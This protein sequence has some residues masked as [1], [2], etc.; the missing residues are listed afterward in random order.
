MRLFETFAIFTATDEFARFSLFSFFQLNLPEQRR[1]GLLMEPQPI[2][3]VNMHE[4]AKNSE[5]ASSHSKSQLS[6]GTEKRDASFR[7]RINVNGSISITFSWLIKQQSS[8]KDDKAVF[9]VTCSL[10]LCFCCVWPVS[11]SQTWRLETSLSAA[12]L[13]GLFILWLRVL[14]TWINQ[15]G[16]N[17]CVSCVQRTDST[18]S[19]ETTIFLLLMKLSKSRH[20]LSPSSVFH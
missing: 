3:M 18:S 17:T 8:S 12:V 9:M 10:Y 5:R 14:L 15:P 4:S 20:V 11:H 7:G 6:G 1:A 13:K 2:T 16:W 19:V